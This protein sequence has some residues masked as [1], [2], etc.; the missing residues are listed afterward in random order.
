MLVFMLLLAFYGFFT[1]LSFRI[2]T[3]LFLQVQILYGASFGLRTNWR[4]FSFLV[5]CLAVRQFSIEADIG[6]FDFLVDFD[7]F[8]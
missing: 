1:S 4:F 8:V 7:K 2:V 6:G 5:G 3:S